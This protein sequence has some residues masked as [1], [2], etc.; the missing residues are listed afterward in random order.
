MTITELRTEIDRGRHERQALLRELAEHRVFQSVLDNLLES[1]Q[2]VQRADEAW[3]AEVFAGVKKPD[4]EFVDTVNNFYQEWI[5][6]A[7]QHLAHLRWL[8]GQGVRF[9]AADRLPQALDEVEGI[10]EERS[11][12]EL[13]RRSLARAWEE[14]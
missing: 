10:L 5:N 1:I 4:Q 13:G 8:E 7:R 9:K 14:D 6:A 3:H 2:Q 12:A 11:L